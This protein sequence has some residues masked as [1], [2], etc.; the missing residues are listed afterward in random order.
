MVDTGI[1]VDGPETV[2]SV[3]VIPYYGGIPF[4]PLVDGVWQ[5]TEVTLNTLTWSRIGIPQQP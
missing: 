3:S 5:R 2:F 1:G 4:W